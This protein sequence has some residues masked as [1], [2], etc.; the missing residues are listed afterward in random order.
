MV[1]S[2]FSFPKFKISIFIFA[3]S[4]C[5]FHSYAQTDSL[6]L[7]PRFD[8]QDGLYLDFKALVANQAT[9]KLANVEAAIFVNPQTNIAHLDSL[10]IQQNGNWISAEEKQY[11]AVVLDGLPYLQVD[12]GEERPVFAALRDMGKISV[13]TYEKD[14]LRQIPFNVYNPKTG[15]PFRSAVIS[16]ASTLEKIK[17]LNFANGQ[18][19]DVNTA[20]VLLWT[21]DDPNFQATLEKMPQDKLRELLPELINNYNQRNAL[22]L[23][24]L[25]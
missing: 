13:F 23:P 1:T 19:L 11:W 25:K 18:V 4:I 10:K 7:T 14:T 5:T 8:F 17:M 15:K 12:R 3:L 2:F 9:V 21:Q 6:I 20:N 24:G 16:R 22:W